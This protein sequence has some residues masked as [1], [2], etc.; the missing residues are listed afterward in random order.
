MSRFK[1]A[2]A[3]IAEAMHSLAKLRPILLSFVVVHCASVPDESRSG[4]AGGGPSAR[5]LDVTPMSG[6]A[7]ATVGPMGGVLTHP[8]GG[9]LL[10]PEGAVE[11]PTRLCLTARTEVPRSSHGERSIAPGFSALPAGQTF[12]RAVEVVVPFDANRLPAGFDPTRVQLRMAPHGTSDF[13]TLQ[14]T[15]DL[16][17]GTVR[18][19]TTHFTDFVPA[20]DPNPVFITTA[21][22]LPNTTVG[23][24]YIQPFTATGGTLPYTWS[25]ASESTAP[26]GFTL[27]SGGE[28]SGVADASFEHAFF[29][30]VRD[31]AGNAVQMATS[32]TS[33]PAPIA[34]PPPSPLPV[35]TAVA[36][37]TIP[38]SGIDTQ[39]FVSGASFVAS[40]SATIGAQGIPTHYVSP[41]ELLATVPATY[42][43]APGTL[44]IGA[45]T[46][47]PG[48]GFANATV[49]V[50]VVG[51]NADAGADGG[52]SVDADAAVADAGGAD[53]SDA[54][55]PC[56]GEYFASPTQLTI[57]QDFDYSMNGAHPSGHSV[58]TSCADGHV[59]LTL[60][61]YG[62]ASALLTPGWYTIDVVP[63]EQV[64]HDWMYYTPSIVREPPWPPPPAGCVPLTPGAI[65][66]ERIVDPN[67]T[68][69]CFTITTD[70]EANLG[71]T[72]YVPEITTNKMTIQGNIIDG[73]PGCDAS[74]ATSR[75]GRTCTAWAWVGPGEHTIDIEVGVGGRFSFSA[76]LSPR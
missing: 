40:T 6:E 11:Q 7:C 33:V 29:V 64:G 34:L 9:Q 61:N 60:G 37:L 8:A 69:R 55:P 20:A 31:A 73:A 35:L 65:V 49:D 41:T 2:A 74:F 10:V 16:A 71:G 17:R 54:T 13:V 23:A 36:P 58:V 72:L 28:L 1:G 68:H 22:V 57:S 43:S 5:D 26:P 15:V 45:Y 52:A 67:H 59:A 14:S 48:G 38:V 24:S 70:G 27:V 66:E 53:A 42:L 3:L 18:A 32:L 76:S 56:A 12:K 51:T 4:G 44:H 62:V 30:V 47:A 75:I 50:Q 25:V 39:I 21:P 19:R 46:P 63:D